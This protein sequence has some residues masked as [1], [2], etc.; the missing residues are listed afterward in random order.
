[1]NGQEGL[2]EGLVGVRSVSKTL[3]KEALGEC[4]SWVRDRV[5]DPV[6]EIG[7]RLTSWWW[8]K[9]GI[10]CVVEGR[11]RKRVDEVRAFPN[12]A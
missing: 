7:E 5:A 1:M 4:S 3:Y 11:F 9:D 2:E 8:I 12:R 6:R 10:D